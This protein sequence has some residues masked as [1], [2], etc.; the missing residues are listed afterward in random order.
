MHRLDVDVSSLAYS[1][2]SGSRLGLVAVLRHRA[3]ALSG[4]DNLEVCTRVRCCALCPTI[5]TH[6]RA[7]AQATGGGF[8]N[9]V[10]NVTLPDN[11]TCNITTSS[12]LP[13]T[14]VASGQIPV[15][16][17]EDDDDD[18]SGETDNRFVFCFDCQQP[19]SFSWDP[20]LGAADGAGGVAQIATSVIAT[21]AVLCMAL[22][23]F[24]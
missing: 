3:A 19:T 8:L 20:S 16:A 15:P 7:L 17:G 24:F 4:N 1:A 5:L 12:L 6:A 21:I 14:A 11:S 10:R 2:T 18:S 9:W 23:S 22:T 13:T